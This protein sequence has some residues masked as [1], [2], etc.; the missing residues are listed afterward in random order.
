MKVTLSDI[1]K[2]SGVS[3]G[4]ASLALNNRPGVNEKTRQ[5]VLEIAQKNGYQ[6]SLNAKS[7]SQKR[8]NLIGL[9]VPNIRNLFYAS[10]VQEI[11]NTLRDRHYK[12][13]LATTA[14]NER[15]EKEMI[16]Q[17]VSFRVDGVILY[18]TIKDIRNPRYLDILRKNGI[19]LIFLAGYYPA[20]EAPHCMSDLYTAI[21]EIVDHMYAQ[22]Y[23]K[24]LYFGGCK[25]IVSNQIKINALKDALA[26][27]EVVFQD[28]D[29][30]VLDHTNFEC[31][32]KAA[33]ELIKNKIDFDAAI[34]G[35]AYSG[36]GVY[37]ALLQAGKTV[38]Q[39]VGIAHMDNLIEPGICILPMTCV[40]QN[41]KEIVSA[42]IEM[43]L[44]SIEGNEQKQ[45]RLIPA[46]LIVREST[47][48]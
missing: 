41:I 7:L 32:Y 39:D 10:I 47:S 28:E 30:I 18:P 9:L 15:Y 1:A 14:N 31:A 43:L 26:R 37:N 29:Y 3:L 22:G 25:A 6:P 13:I 36:F 4:T 12:M 23:R 8:S 42:T 35:D 17:F 46:K 27:H 16:E 19:P 48:R 45:N 5:K 11:E 38:P 21:G 40:E 24:F 44:D 33:E 2:E 34:T 20:I